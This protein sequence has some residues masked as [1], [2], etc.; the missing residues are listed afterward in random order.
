LKTPWQRGSNVST[1]GLLRPFMPKG[2]D[3]RAYARV[4]LDEIE[5]KVN[6]RP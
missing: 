3:L 4:D 2:T 1:N 5:R 6:G